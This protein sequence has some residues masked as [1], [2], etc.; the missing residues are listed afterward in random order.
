RPQ[1]L[2]DPGNGQALASRAALMQAEIAIGVEFAGVPEHADLI[3]PTKTMRRAPSVNSGRFAT[4]FFAISGTPLGSSSA[5]HLLHAVAC[6]G[7]L[8]R[9]D[10]FRL[11]RGRGMLLAQSN[12]ASDGLKAMASYAA[13]L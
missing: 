12:N 10:R 7:F 9:P 4:K 13:D 1:P 5:P 11:N 8:A 3:S 6:Y 2:L